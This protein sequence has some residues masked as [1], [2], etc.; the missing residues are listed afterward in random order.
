M[1]SGYLADNLYGVTLPPEP[2]V[3]KELKIVN[4]MVSERCDFDVIVNFRQV[5]ILTSPSLANLITLHD[6]VQGSG[7]RLVL[8]NM[9]L[10]TKSIFIATGLDAFFHFAD[11]RDAAVEACRSNLLEHAESWRLS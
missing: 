10:T 11:S 7:H 5:E 3:S 8:Y 4:E 9:S 1:A 6:L 2:G